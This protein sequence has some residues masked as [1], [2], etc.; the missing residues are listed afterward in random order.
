MQ[1]YSSDLHSIFVLIE[2]HKTED[3]FQVLNLKYEK[4]NYV[5][6]MVSDSLLYENC[7]PAF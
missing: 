7:E 1:Q 2:S 3:N 5:C 4:M 6:H